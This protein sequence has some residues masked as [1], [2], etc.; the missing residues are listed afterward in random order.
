[1]AAGYSP[2]CGNC[3]FGGNL[4]VPPYGGL[5]SLLTA[6]AGVVLLFKGKYPKGIFQYILNMNRWIYRVSVNTSL[7]KD[8][9]PPFR[10]GGKK[11][12]KTRIEEIKVKINCPQN[13]MCIESGY[14]NLCKG[15]DMRVEPYIECLDEHPSRC[16]FSIRFGSSYWCK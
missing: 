6:I 14:E 9:Y 10:L 5:V 12:I 11:D 1:M 13:Y 7:M 16:S 3:F 15:Q 2:L 4:G 8:R